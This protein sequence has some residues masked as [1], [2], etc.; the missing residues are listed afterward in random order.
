MA[1]TFQVK[2]LTM[3]LLVG[4]MTAPTGCSWFKKDPKQQEGLGSMPT[5][6]SQAGPSVPGR[7]APDS[8]EP[9][10]PRAGDTLPL[11]DMKRIYFDY[12]R[13]SLRPDQLA[14]MEFNLKYLMER[15]EIKLLITGHC[16]ENGSTEYNF[17]LGER[18]AASVRD[19]LVK[20]GINA[21]RVVTLSKGE[22]EPMAL[23]HDEQ[24][25]KLNRRCEFER[26]Y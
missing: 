1:R 26:M 4:V 6:T 7:T 19:Y 22:E 23:G 9:E 18:R 12:D 8:V 13:A 3:F 2:V 24:S 11:P 10:G 17:A 25:W 16:D 14:N 15:P 20:G 5:H 21:G